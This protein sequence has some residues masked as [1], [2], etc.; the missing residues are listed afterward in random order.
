MA[1]A[2]GGCALRR[3]HAFLQRDGQNKPTA[4]PGRPQN[5]AKQKNRADRARRAG[6][7]L[8]GLPKA[9]TGTLPVIYVICVNDEASPDDHCTRIFTKEK[10]FEGRHRP[11][12]RD[13]RRPTTTDI[14]D[15][16]LRKKRA[17]VE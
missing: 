17:M 12:R 16:L 15:F 3:P 13:L 2:A 6:L 8:E 10:W 14:Q 11:L 7:F 5:K 9:T 4:T 1:L